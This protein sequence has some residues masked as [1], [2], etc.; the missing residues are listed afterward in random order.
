MPIWEKYQKIEEFKSNYPNIKTYR[1]KIEIIIKEIIPKDINDYLSIK[2]RLNIIK[3]KYNIYEIIEENDKLYIV[4]D[5]EKEKDIDRLILSNEFN[6]QNEGVLEGH[7][8]PIKKDE[9]VELFKMEKS[10]C[11]ISFERIKKAN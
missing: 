1:A 4:I 9:I 8:E 11:K 10:M 7:G 5:K 2:E 6:I 3:N